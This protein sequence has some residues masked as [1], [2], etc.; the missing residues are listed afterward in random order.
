M[1]VPPIKSPD[2][3]HRNLIYWRVIHKYSTSRFRVFGWGILHMLPSVY[4]DSN[5]GYEKSLTSLY[6]HICFVLNGNFTPGRKINGNFIQIYRILS[7]LYI[8]GFS[9]AIFLVK[10]SK[11]RE[12]SIRKDTPILKPLAWLTEFIVWWTF[13]SK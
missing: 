5:T 12:N 1:Y 7:L 4:Y 8:F 6:V 11:I 13:N 3:V 2:F 10:N 9:A